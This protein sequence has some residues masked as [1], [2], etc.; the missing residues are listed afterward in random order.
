[1]ETY[2]RR[3]HRESRIE[4]CFSAVLN[5]S[6]HNIIATDGFSKFSESV[7]WFCLLWVKYTNSLLSSTIVTAGRLIRLSEMKVA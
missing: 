4:V 7:F 1:M 3:T 6:K 2:G 5:T